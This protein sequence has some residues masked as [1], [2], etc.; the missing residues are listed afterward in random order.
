[1]CDLMCSQVVLYIC[2]VSVVICVVNIGDHDS[3]WSCFCLFTG[4]QTC[5]LRFN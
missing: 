3:R 4:T 1:M 2:F 5:K